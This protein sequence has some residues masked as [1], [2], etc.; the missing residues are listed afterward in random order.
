MTPLAASATA[1]QYEGR[2]DRANPS[3]PVLIWA[4]SRVRVDF[5]GPV[6]AVVFGT[7]T[8]QSYFDLTVDGVTEVVAGSAGRYVCPHG[9]GTGRHRLEL[10]KRSEADAG[11]VAFHGVELAAGAQAWA[12]EPRAYRFRMEFI[13][14]SITAG[15]NNEDGAVDQWEDRRTHNH[16]LSY[17]YLTSQAF[18]ADHRAMAVSGMG[19]CEGFVPM[20][21]GEAWDKVYPRDNPR[22]ADLS[23]W[24]PE[25]VCVNLG[26]NDA[27]FTQANGRP[28]PAGFTTAYVALIKAVRA[29]YPA[30]HIV[31]LRGGMAGGATNPELRA[32]WAAAVGELEAADP[33][34]S[35][36]VFQH[37]T[38]QHPRVRD[39]RVMA[40]ELTAW[41]KAQGWMGPHI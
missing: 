33:A 12:P 17:G 25:V 18:G 31:L 37:W 36:F 7:A 9:L 22:R 6:L 16:A 32:A 3:Q 27:A 26:E 41:L 35:H 40:A 38:E 5:E 15:A 20:V 34:I 24:V 21:A 11:Q 2:L 4:G 13:G 1:F 30:A 10:L 8:G 19:L 23:V 28:F 39:H 29:A 14:D